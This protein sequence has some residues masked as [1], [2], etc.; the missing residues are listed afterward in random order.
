MRESLGIENID[1]FLNELLKLPSHYARK[2]TTK[3]FLEPVFRTLTDVY[4]LY[5]THC[6]EINLQP[7]T[8]K[9]FYRRFNEKDLSI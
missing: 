6:V 7:I 5:K 9:Y 4:K 3:L 1:K 2:D 8:K